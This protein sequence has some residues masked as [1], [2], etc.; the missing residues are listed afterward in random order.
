MRFLLDENIPKDFAVALRSEGHDT[1]RVSETSLRGG[2]DDAVW[3]FAV[4]DNRIVVTADLDF[5][6]AAPMP[7]G[8]ILLR[9]F[10]RISTQALMELLLSAIRSI[11]DE[12]VGSLLVISP[13]RVRKRRLS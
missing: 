9:G 2:D 4:E 7:A 6:L 12:L 11:G 13:G 1:V 8:L 3:A 10:D 5:P